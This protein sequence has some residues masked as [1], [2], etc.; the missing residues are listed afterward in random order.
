MQL[1]ISIKYLITMKNVVRL[2][3]HSSCQ[4]GCMREVGGGEWWCKLLPVSCCFRCCERGLLF[5]LLASIDS[6]DFTDAAG[7]D[8]EVLTGRPLTIRVQ[9]QE[10]LLDVL[11]LASADEAEWQRD[12]VGAGFICIPAIWYCVFPGRRATSEREGDDRHKLS[13]REG[14]REERDVKIVKLSAFR[15]IT[16]RN[17]RY[18]M[19]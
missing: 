10:F 4:L 1:N 2:L 8:K 14:T 5:L 15:E 6:D 7:G 12:L 13:R 16:E 18:C 3:L 19:Q 11:L 17:V 9:G